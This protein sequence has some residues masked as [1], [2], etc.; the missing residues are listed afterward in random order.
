[1]TA[2][3]I[4]LKYGSIDGLTLTMDG[5]GGGRE[6]LSRVPEVR[7]RMAGIYAF[8]L[9]VLN[10]DV[11]VNRQWSWSASPLSVAVFH[12]DTRRGLFGTLSRVK[13]RRTLLG[14]PAVTVLKGSEFEIRTA[15]RQLCF[16]DGEPVSARDTWSIVRSPRPVQLVTPVRSNH[17]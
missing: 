12:A 14:D 15:E 11:S 16:S 9:D 17:L 6:Q 5:G 10:H 1:M 4:A 2:A 3:A 13:K 8:A 7:G